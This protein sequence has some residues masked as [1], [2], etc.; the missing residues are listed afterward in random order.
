MGDYGLYRKIIAGTTGGWT[1]P[2]RAMLGMMAVPYSVGVA[3][4]NRWYDRPGAT[5]RLPAPVISV[6]NLTT[7]GTGKT[8]LVIDL[9]QRLIQLGRKPAVLTR[10]YGAGRDGRNDEALLVERRCPDATC[11]VDADRYRGGMRAFTEFG[12]DVFVL[13][14]GFQHRRLARDL[15]IVLLDA[16]C[17][18]GYERLLPRGLLREPPSEL[19]RAQLIALTRCDQATCEEI[20]ELEA[21]VRAAAPNAT[22]LRCYHRVAAIE[23]LDGVPVTDSLAGRRAALFAAIGHPQAFLTTARQLGLEVVGA[24]WRPDHY[25]YRRRDLRA[26]VLDGRFPAHDLLLTTEKDAVKLTRMGCAKL[27]PVRTYVVKIAIDFLGDGS[28]MLDSVLRRLS[29]QSS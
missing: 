7:G 13:D 9:V 1:G 12:A 4:R 25:R 2:L 10:G 16:T 21:R 22:R 11:I 29:L 15:D 28:T 19:R 17:P 3:A 20:T 8:P 18:F 5:R 26:L 14:D 27:D 23:R 6:G 24:C